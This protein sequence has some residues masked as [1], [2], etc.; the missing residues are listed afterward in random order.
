MAN[1]TRNSKSN[2]ATTTN[3]SKAKHYM[4]IYMDGQQIG[5]A[6]V[7]EEEG[8]YVNLVFPPPCDLAWVSNSLPSQQMCARIFENFTYAEKRAKEVGKQCRHGEN[9]LKYSF[10]YQEPSRFSSSN[11]DVRIHIS[12]DVDP[13]LLTRTLRLIREISC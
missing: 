5:Y 1:I 11:V 4:N 9:R 10:W 7:A 8:E 13:V 12:N 3:D 2:T 6:F